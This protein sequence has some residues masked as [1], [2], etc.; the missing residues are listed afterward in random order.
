[1]A[2]IEG[3]ITQNGEILI[4]GYIC[5]NGIKFNTTFKLDTGVWAS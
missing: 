2:I 1:M 4:D 3:I 5:K